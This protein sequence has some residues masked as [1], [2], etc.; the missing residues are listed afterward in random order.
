[1]TEPEL[2]TLAMPDSNS[3]NRV[4]KEAMAW[5][6]RQRTGGLSAKEQ[7]LFQAWQAKSPAHR[8]AYQDVQALWDDT[9]F[10]Q[11]IRLASLKRQP[12]AESPVPLNKRHTPNRGHWL[13]FGLAASFALCVVLLDPITR[14]QADYYTPVGGNQ[15][16][17]LADGSIV[18][19]NTNTAIKVAFSGNERRIRLIEGEAYFDVRHLD[20]QPFIVEADN[21]ETRVVGT[22][23]MVRT[24]QVE[25]KITV[26]KGLVN[27]SNT[28]QNQSVFLHP[29]QQVSNNASG[30]STVRQLEGSQEAFWLNG[31]LSLQDVPLEHAVNEL[32]RY[33]PGLVVITGNSLKAYRISGRFNITQPQHALTTLERTLPITVTTIGGWLTVIR[34]R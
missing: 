5:F 12:V 9:D 15:A 24:T 11:A 29:D 6:S 3:C 8:Q 1:M 17:T 28:L 25:E 4:D 10:N 13:S 20:G 32:A 33:L 27:V 34:P 21:T 22:Q 18:T 16:I 19:L 30:L 14:L 31:R 2:D 23:F 7:A 26:I